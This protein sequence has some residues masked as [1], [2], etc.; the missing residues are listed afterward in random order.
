MRRVVNRSLEATSSVRI[1]TTIVIHSPRLSTTLI[2]FTLLGNCHTSIALFASSVG[3]VLNLS[4][5]RLVIG[6]CAFDAVELT[7]GERDA[8]RY[9]ER[10]AYR[11][12]IE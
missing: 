9:T 10:G 2:D 5:K 8:V 4:P 6:V 7:K 12:V 11:E 3:D 1:K